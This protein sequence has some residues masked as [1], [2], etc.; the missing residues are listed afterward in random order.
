[1]FNN[2]G[3]QKGHTVF[4]GK[5]KEVFDE[6]RPRNIGAR[7]LRIKS[8]PRIDKNRSRG[9]YFRKVPAE[10][11]INTRRIRMNRWIGCFSFFCVFVLFLPGPIPAQENAGANDSVTMLEEVVV[12]ATRQKE[13]ISSVPANVS[14]ITESDIENS[15]ARDVPELLRTSAGVHVNDISGN[16]RSYTVD[17]RGFGETAALNTLVQVDGRRINQADLSGTDWTL[18]PLDRIERIEIARGGR[19]SVLYG[20]NSG[21]GVI[22]IITKEGRDFQA[23]VEAAGGSYDTWKTDAQVSGSQK[24]LSYAVSGSYLS[25]DGYRDNSDTRAKDVGVNLGYFASDSIKLNLSSG[26]HEDKTG[27]P[28][29]ITESEFDSG[30]SRTDTLRPYDY[31]DVEDYYVK[32]GPEIYFWNNSLFKIDMSFRNRESLFFSSFT[33]GT[34]TGNTEINSVSASPQLVF[35]ENIFGLDHN[36]TVGMDYVADEEDIVNTSSYTGTDRFELKKKNYGFYIH[37]ELNATE[38][39]SISGGYRYDKA[40]FTFEPSTPD[41]TEASED[42][43]TA[44]AS[45]K[46]KENSQVYFSFSRSFRYPVLDEF[47]NF[48]YNTIDTEMKPQTSDN[49]ELGVKHAFSDSLYGNIN[50]FRIDTEDE[51]LYNPTAGLFGANENLDAETQR[52]GIEIMLTKDFDSLQLKGTYSYTDATIEGGQFDGND[53][54][55]VPEH[56]ASLTS[57]FYLMKNLTL[58]LNGVY[59]GE[60]PF[61]SDFANDFEDQDDYFVA[62]AKVQYQ[63]KRMNAYL[64]VNNLFDKE[65]SEYGVLNSFLTERAYY[66][67][68]ETNFLLGFS[69]EL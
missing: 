62:N 30:V 25:S 59:V 22:N 21:G 32:G 47:F 5:R 50:I 36:L 42:L 17:L 54:P 60:R 49:Y 15:P 41:E 40:E 28:G 39:L 56:Q 38:K 67:S 20:D 63:W 58:A 37:E 55:G 31:T 69:L 8:H 48:Q 13:E 23:K 29:A 46:Y 33:G 6:D 10:E 43:Y 51:I 12:T 66:P 34:Y 53:F 64:K 35:R 18:I 16:R 26:Y 68:P 4:K 57:T 2:G 65:Y 11:F 52:D 7:I 19:G 44:G 14:V 61:I 27:L 3:K 9:V 45:Y 24:S 1:M